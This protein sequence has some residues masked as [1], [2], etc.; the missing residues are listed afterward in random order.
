MSLVYGDALMVHLTVD[1]RQVR[2]GKPA[3]GFEF[4]YSLCGIRLSPI[5]VRP[6][7]I[8]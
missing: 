3:M 4:D 5:A 8:R 7:R 1:S 2:Y 6:S